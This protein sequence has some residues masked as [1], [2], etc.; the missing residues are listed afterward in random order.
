MAGEIKSSSDVTLEKIMVELAKVAFID[1]KNGRNMAAK[2][3]ALIKLAILKGF[4]VDD[5]PVAADKNK[6]EFDK[7]T[8]E[9]QRKIFDDK[10]KALQDD[11]I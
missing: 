5:M 2:T 10:I 1:V 9:E 4:I 6:D 7:L 8:P 3:S 11:G